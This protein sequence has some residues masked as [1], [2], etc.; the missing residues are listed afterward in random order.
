MPRS[1]YSPANRNGARWQR[2]WAAGRDGLHGD[3]G[4]AGP[5]SRRGPAFA[6]CENR[7][8]DLV[9]CTGAEL[10]IGWLPVLL[11]ESGNGRFSPASQGISKRPAMCPDG[12][13]L[14]A[15]IAARAMC[16][17]RAIRI[18]RPIRAISPG[19]R[20]R[21]AEPWPKWISARASRLHQHREQAFQLRWAQ[22]IKGWEAKAAPLKGVAVCGSAQGLFLICKTGLAESRS[23]CWS[24][25]RALS[26]LLP[27]SPR[28]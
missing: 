14:L 22:A 24:P 3:D 20:T 5:S 15:W 13:C 16:M 25:S 21:L 26:L 11:N 1:M 10:E 9:V 28:C 18:S 7:Q 17:L 23:P 6:D 19:W 12:E 2:S 8:A 4:H 27:I